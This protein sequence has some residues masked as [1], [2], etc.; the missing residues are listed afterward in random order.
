MPAA[1]SLQLKKGVTNSDVNGELVVGRL[2]RLLVARASVEDWFVVDKKSAG[3]RDQPT[4]NNVTL[5]HAP[6]E[7]R[8]HRI[9][10]VFKTVHSSAMEI[11]TI[12][13]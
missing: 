8:T 10:N 5:I 11:P 4:L 9:Q 7:T 13:T 6:F 3:L 1:Q 12:V 2:V